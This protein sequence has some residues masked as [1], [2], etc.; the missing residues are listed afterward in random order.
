ME[1]SAA[2]RKD[3]TSWFRCPTSARVHDYLAGGRDNFAVD[4][5]LGDRMLEAVP[6]LAALADV[7]WEFTRRATLAAVEQ[8]IAQFLDLGC[9]LPRPVPK[10]EGSSRRTLPTIHRTA[11]AASPNPDRVR[12]TYVDFDPLVMNHARAHLTDGGAVRTLAAD[13]LDTDALF[14]APEVAGHLDLTSPIAVSIHA[15]LHWIPDDDAV[16]HALRGIVS[17]LPAGSTVS[18]THA[19]ADHTPAIRRALADAF[20]DS[21]LTLRLRTAQQLHDLLHGLVLLPPGLAPAG[22][23]NAGDAASTDTTTWAGV[24]FKPA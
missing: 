20:T 12:T 19:T 5:V 3:S 23:W 13:L 18:I 6:Q 22:S 2:T 11:A 21:D 16:R 9:G 24:G 15:T 1:T 10:W 4:R 17:C 14:T 8:G 7:N